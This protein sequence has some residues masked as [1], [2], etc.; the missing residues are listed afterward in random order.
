MNEDARFGRLEDLVPRDAWGHEAHAFTPWLAENLHSLTDAVGMELE[1]TGQEVPVERYAADI[2]ARNVAD[3]TLVLIENQLEDTD[4]THLGQIMTYLAGLDART[5]IWISP[6]FREPHLSAVRWLNEHTVDGFSFFA[7]RLRIVRIGAS[8]MAPVF[9]V[10]EKPNGWERQLSAARLDHA[11]V[12]RRERCRA[13]WSY[14]ADCDEQ[15]RFKVMT[16]QYHLA[17]PSAYARPALVKIVSQ[18]GDKVRTFVENVPKGG[19][20]K[21]EGGAVEKLIAMDAT[22]AERLDAFP[23]H[24]PR[25]LCKVGPGSL[26]DEATWDEAANWLI[27]ERDCYEAVLIPL[28]RDLEPRA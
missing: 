15:K 8:P 17:P 12:E 18:V 10:E 28:L 27:Q 6:K 20:R 13:F 16:G 9:E 22:R 7:V 24:G 5:V 25:R 2:L 1:L 21:H 11:S 23:I 3:D 19:I 14:V 4:H 26:A